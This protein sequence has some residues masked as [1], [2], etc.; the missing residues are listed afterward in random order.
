MLFLQR[1]C[2]VIYW[3][4]PL[5][6]WGS[7]Q[8]TKYREYACDD[9]VLAAGFSAEEYLA[10]LTRLLGHGSDGAPRKLSA[11]LGFLWERQ[12]VLKRMTRL[13]H[14]VRRPLGTS[15]RTVHVACHAFLLLWALSLVLVRVRASHLEYPQAGWTRW[16][17]GSAWCLH[18]LGVAA[19][20]FELDAHR[21]NP[22][23][24]TREH[25]L[26]ERRRRELAGREAVVP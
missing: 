16:P 9:A 2:E 13:L 11:A 14:A 12:I 10:C 23:E 22:R 17:K 1:I 18:A 7:W 15:R 19:R 20:D 5:L 24:N 8:V 25:I 6:W 3:Y 21:N 26:A 4:H